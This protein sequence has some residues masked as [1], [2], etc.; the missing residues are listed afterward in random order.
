MAEVKSIPISQIHVPP[1]LREV[2]EDHARAI[3]LSLEAHGLI[4]PITLRYAPAKNKGTTP[5]IL[6]AGAHRLAGATILGWT[7]IEAAIIEADQSE[8]QLVEICENLFRNELSALDRAIFVASYRDVWEQAHGKIRAGRPEK[9]GQVGP[10]SDSPLDLISKEAGSGFSE[11]IAER[12]GVSVRNIKRLGQIAKSLSPAVR[13]AVRGTAAADNQ[14][15]LLSV[16]KRPPAEQQA[17]VSTMQAAQLDLPTVLRQI[18]PAP[19]KVDPQE[20]IFAT[21][22]AAW[23]KADEATRARFIDHIQQKKAAAK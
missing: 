18:K 11:H 22:S 4:N 21:L 14:S 9:S 19:A 16:A 12:M 7:E 13:A 1:R 10:I 8:A 2:E 15:L 3:A 23:K 5:Y 6:V 20:A 17:I